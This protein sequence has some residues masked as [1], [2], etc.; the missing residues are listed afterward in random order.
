[1]KKILF[2]LFVLFFLLQ[3]ITANCQDIWYTQGNFSP[4]KRV[5]LTLTNTLNF[6]RK[7]VPIAIPRHQFAVS[8]YQDF[9]LTVVDPLGESRPDAG[10]KQIHNI[11]C[12]P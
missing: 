2:S 9:E 4:L 5:A 11:L 6:D 8:D 12:V 3:T 1:M 10:K 7:D